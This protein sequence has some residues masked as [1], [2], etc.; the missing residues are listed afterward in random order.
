MKLDKGDLLEYR[1]FRLLTHTGYL[2]M[3]GQLVYTTEMLNPVTDIDLFGIK[4]DLDFSRN[5]II[6]ESKNRKK[7]GPLDRVL[8]LKGLKNLVGAKSAILA[9]P[10]IKW[11]IKDYAFREGIK[12]IDSTS[13]NYIESSLN[14]SEQKYFALADYEFYEPIYPTWKP[15][16]SYDNRLSRLFSFINSDAKNFT[17]HKGI[18]RVF[19]EIKWL[20]PKLETKQKNEAQLTK[21]LLYRITVYL[22]IYILDLCQYFQLLS[23]SERE[24]FLQKVLSFG[25]IPQSLASGLLSDIWRIANRLSKEQ[26]GKAMSIPDEFYKFPIPPYYEGVLEVL[27]RFCKNPKSAIKSPRILDFVLFEFLFKNKEIEVEL[28]KN[29]LDIQ[30]DFDIKQAKNVLNLLIKFGDIPNEFYDKFLAL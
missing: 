2:V 15:I 17:P 7:L 13:L 20:L 11:D 27:D 10:N 21:W 1:Y 8:W 26:F 18:N 12:I 24:G 3:K 23:N 16:L 29:V 25:D 28:L 22:S 5:I 9:V 14:L 6:I 4:Y 19:S 30:T